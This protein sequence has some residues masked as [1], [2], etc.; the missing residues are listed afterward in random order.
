MGAVC[1]REIDQSAAGKPKRRARRLLWRGDQ[2]ADQSRP[3]IRF[4]RQALCFSWH[5]RPQDARPH[6]CT[7]VLWNQKTIAERM[8]SEGVAHKCRFRSPLEDRAI[9]FDILTRWYF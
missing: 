9:S 1:F 8:V 3:S 5:A 7:K 2:Q 4:D 6:T